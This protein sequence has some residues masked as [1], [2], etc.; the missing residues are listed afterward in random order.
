MPPA[1]E[2]QSLNHWTAREVLGIL[3]LQAQFT[4]VAAQGHEARKGRARGLDERLSVSK[5][6]GFS[7]RAHIYSLLGTSA[8]EASGLQSEMKVRFSVIIDWFT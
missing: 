5:V 8:L 3:I 7:S 4:Y 1:V 2:A 6:Q